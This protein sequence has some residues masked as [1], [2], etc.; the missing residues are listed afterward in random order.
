MKTTSY[1]QSAFSYQRTTAAAGLP[2]AVLAY[3]R[4]NFACP[5]I[6]SGHA[7]RVSVFRRMNFAYAGM[8]LGYARMI[9][10]CARKFL[11]CAK[12]FFARPGMFSGYAKKFFACAGKVPAY[13]WMNLACPGSFPA[14]YRK[15][16]GRRV[17][18]TTNQQ[19]RRLTT[20]QNA[21]ICHPMMRRFCFSTIS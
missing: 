6:I 8:I 14:C 9:L 19:E 17:F 12:T 10:A 16:F 11:G 21:I 5:G 15:S 4:M 3:T 20:W 1:Q 7:R 2:G 13:R 18:T